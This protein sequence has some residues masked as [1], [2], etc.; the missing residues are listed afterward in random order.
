MW[1]VVVILC[2]AGWIAYRWSAQRNQ[3]L[4]DSKAVESDASRRSAR[5]ME[6][7]DTMKGDSMRRNSMSQRDSGSQVLDAAGSEEYKN[8]DSVRV[9]PCE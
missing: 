2:C 7:A 5:A 4:V 1:E 8:E 3:V 6:R 9:E